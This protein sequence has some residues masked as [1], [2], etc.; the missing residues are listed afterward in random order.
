MYNRN[1]YG[2]NDVKKLGRNP[3]E[4]IVMITTIYDDFI[5][6]IS[7]FNLRFN[8]AICS[9]VYENTEREAIV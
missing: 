8:N 5:S 6:N 4:R 2:M 3:E 9:N 1:I 7:S